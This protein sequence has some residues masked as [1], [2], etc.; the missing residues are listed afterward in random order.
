[1]ATKIFTYDGSYSSFINSL[2]VIER[3][4]KAAITLASKGDYHLAFIQFRRTCNAIPRLPQGYKTHVDILREITYQMKENFERSCKEAIESH[5]QAM[6]DVLAR[7]KK[8]EEVTELFNYSF[9]EHAHDMERFANLSSKIMLADIIVENLC[10]TGV[11][12]DA[13]LNQV[14]SI[15]AEPAPNST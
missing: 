15:F 3:D 7:A 11:M 9:E 4:R 13:R 6:H 14:E 2:G 12:S 5:Y 10:T 8:G 1:M